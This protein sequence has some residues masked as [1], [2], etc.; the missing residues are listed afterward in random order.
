MS[1]G[2]HTAPDDAHGSAPSGAS[3]AWIAPLKVSPSSSMAGRPAVLSPFPSDKEYPLWRRVFW[4]SKI[5]RRC[6]L[7][8]L[9][10]AG[11]LIQGWHGGPSRGNHTSRE[12]GR[13]PIITPRAHPLLGVREMCL[14]GGVDGYLSRP[15]KPVDLPDMTVQISR[16]V[17]P[18]SAYARPEVTLLV[19]SK[20]PGKAGIHTTFE[21]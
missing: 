14:A 10:S 12:D 13:R 1:C 18:L 15:I 4:S 9:S 16:G 21:S 5:I 19:N 17:D 7:Q 20:R 6:S 2:G 3:A 11:C 8:N